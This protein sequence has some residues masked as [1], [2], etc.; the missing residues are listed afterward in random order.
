MLVS[1]GPLSCKM[2]GKREPGVF[3]RHVKDYYIYTKSGQ[4]CVG[5]P[6]ALAVAF[7]E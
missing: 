7:L 1:S 5:L 6:V 2:E 3:N 4:L